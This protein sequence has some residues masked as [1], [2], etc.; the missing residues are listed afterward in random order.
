[1]KGGYRMSFTVD[2][3]KLELKK[4]RL[5]AKDTICCLKLAKY[6]PYSQVSLTLV[7]RLHYGLRRNRILQHVYLGA[8]ASF[9]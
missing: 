6:D 4:L 8:I 3:Y 9:G 2:E 7:R 5:I 1:M